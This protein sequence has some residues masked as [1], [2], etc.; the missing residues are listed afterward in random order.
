MY[1]LCQITTWQKARVQQCPSSASY[2]CAMVS[3]QQKC[4]MCRSL[5]TMCGLI[6]TTRR[7]PSSTPRQKHTSQ[8]R[9]GMRLLASIGNG[10]R[11]PVHSFSSEYRWSRV[12]Q[13]WFT[14]ETISCSRENEYNTFLPI[15]L[16]SISR[17]LVSY[18]MMIKLSAL[19]FRHLKLPHID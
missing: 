8:I 10:I 13:G 12:V 9:Q 3:T 6:N 19:Y 15:L 1:Q 7:S 14:K 4:S 17:F 5:L 2:S 18:G 16:H 11:S